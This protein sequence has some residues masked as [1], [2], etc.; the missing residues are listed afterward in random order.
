LE[1]GLVQFIWEF[2]ALPDKMEEFERHYSASGPWAELFRRSA[3]F[4]S[5]QL[6]RDSDNARRFLTIDRWE[7]V[8]SYRAMRERFAKEYDDLDRAYEAFTE[9]E[10]SIG[11]FEEK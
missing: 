5:T 6:L 7:S 10:R 8:A 4:R 1:A 2:I 3:G 11:V 9:T